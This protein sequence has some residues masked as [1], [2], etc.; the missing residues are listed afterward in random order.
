M[1]EIA[2]LAERFDRFDGDDATTR[3]DL[4]AVHSELPFEAQ[5]SALFSAKQDEGFQRVVKIIVATNAAESSLT[6]PDVDAVVDCC[7]RKEPTYERET[8]RVVLRHVWS[9]KATAQQ[10]AG[11]TGRVGPGVAYHLAA[12][13]LLDAVQD[14]DTPH[15][16]AHP[17]DQVVLGLRSSLPELHTFLLLAD[18]PTPPDEDHVAD[19]LVMLARRRLIVDDGSCPKTDETTARDI[20]RALDTAPLTP[21]GSLA[22]ALPVRPPFA[23]IQRGPFLFEPN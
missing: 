16:Q 18:F 10:R 12:R 22:A 20:I 4:V 13:K 8:D 14:H 9:S 2:E 6:L 7:S 23:Q 5:R 11:R 15:V 1:A 19:A 3:Y 17:L 21:A